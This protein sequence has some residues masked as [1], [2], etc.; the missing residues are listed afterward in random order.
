M[1]KLIIYT[2]VLHIS[3]RCNKIAAS[4]EGDFAGISLFSE[5][6]CFSC[7]FQPKRDANASQQTSNHRALGISRR[8]KNHRS[9][10]RSGQ[11]R[12]SQSR[13]H[14]QRHEP[15]QHR[16]GDRPRPRHPQPNRRATRRV[17]Q[18]LHL[19]Y[20]SR[21]SPDR[22]PPPCRRKPLRLSAD[23][24]DR[25]LRTLTRGRNIHLRRRTRKLT[26]GGSDHRHDGHRRRCLKLLEGLPVVRRSERK[27]HR[28]Q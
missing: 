12:R 25:Y 22:S 6:T 24:I 19:L 10:P 26:L 7:S 20:P 18:R 27:K 28:D 5:K 15:Y 16:C 1:R 21:R 23:R 2:I 4:E 17:L 11:S 8:W 14:R 3:I 9:E 13:C